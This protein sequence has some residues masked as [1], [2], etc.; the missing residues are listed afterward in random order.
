MSSIYPIC[1]NSWSLNNQLRFYYSYHFILLPRRGRHHL[2]A[3]AQTGLITPKI[4]S[5]WAFC[6]SSTRRSRLSPLTHEPHLIFSLHSSRPP[7]FN[8]EVALQPPPYHRLYFC[9]FF[10]CTIC[11]L[12]QVSS[13]CLLPACWCTYLSYSTL[14]SRVKLHAL[15]SARRAVALI[16]IYAHSPKDLSSLELLVFEPVLI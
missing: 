16:R 7:I 14:Y 15:G 5:C 8:L 9:T 3:V 13:A 6:L 10:V 2:E 12:S 1:V 11:P 4:P